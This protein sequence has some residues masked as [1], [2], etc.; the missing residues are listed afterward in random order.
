[1]KE[2]QAGFTLIELMIV[3]VIVAILAAIAIPSYENQMKKGRRA[4]AQTFLLDI[5][6]RQQQF[7]LDARRYATTIVELNI[8]VPPEVTPFYNVTIDPPP[9]GPPPTFVIRATPAGT[10]AA[11]GALTLNEQGV[12]T[13]VGSTSGWK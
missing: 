11:D 4:A 9:A 3:V 12:K 10:Q 5:A 2:K 7:L 6:N 8:T 1:M 13:R